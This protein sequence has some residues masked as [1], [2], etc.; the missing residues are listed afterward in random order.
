MATKVLVLGGYGTTGTILSELLLEHGNADIVLAGR[1]LARAERAAH[2]L[3]GRYP[4]R[5]TATTCDAADAASLAGALSG[6]GLVA[7]AASVLPHAQAIAEA[8][9]AA[10]ADYFDLLLSS[11]VK[12]TALERLR[13][14]IEAEG[15]CFITDGGIHPGLSAAMIRAL[16]P[17][18]G[19]LERADVGGLM[20]LDWAAYDF[21]HDTV[22]EFVNEL[23]D[24]RIETLHGG[25]WGKVAMRRAMR[26]IDFGSPFK[27]ERCV[28]M[29]LEE[30]RLLP[31]HV[32]SLRD[33]GFYVAGFNPVVDNVIMPLG[34]VVM[35]V[36]PGLL[37]E[38]CAGVMSWAL[39]RFARPPYGVVWRVE[40]AGRDT[41]GTPLGAVVRLEHA[42]GYWLTAAA[43]A[44]CLLQ[45][46]D[47][48]LSDP[49]LHL[50]ALAVDPQR[51]LADLQTMGV[52]L[53]ARGVALDTILG[54]GAARPAE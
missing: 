1:D 38:P 8:A 53:E 16:E 46:L 14:R 13:P 9:L 20:K 54:K 29:A 22:M 17:A 26:T 21:G 19:R 39:R 49:G 44:C 33:C 25:V 51:L 15:R 28:P 31:E 45:R 32:P 5:V 43:A 11:P 18:F 30:L 3:A 37:A 36:A 40:A 52:R 10:G 35:K 6:V 7:V 27:A 47:G 2:A 48:T 23:A 34:M 42:D 4:G 41:A 50:Q 24:Y 12:L